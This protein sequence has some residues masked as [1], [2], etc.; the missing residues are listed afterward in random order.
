MSSLSELTEDDADAAKKDEIVKTYDNQKETKRVVVG[1]T[2]PKPLTVRCKTE[3]SARK[4][5][6]KDTGT[7]FQF[8]H[9]SL[10]SKRDLHKLPRLKLG[11]GMSMDLS[12][13]VTDLRK[14]SLSLPSLGASK[15]PNGNNGND[16]EPDEYAATV[17]LETMLKVAD[18]SSMMQDWD[19]YKCWSSRLYFELRHAYEQ[20]RNPHDPARNWF[21]A[22]ILFWDGYVTPLAKR[23]ESTGAFFVAQT[24]DH[25]DGLLLRCVADNRA[26]WL[27][28]GREFTAWLAKKWSV[29]R[30]EERK[31]K[32]KKRNIVEEKACLSTEGDDVKHSDSESR[33][34][35]IMGRLKCVFRP[36]KTQREL[37]R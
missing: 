28:E 18:V 30:E 26:R 31:K 27:K 5:D 11:I 6:S 22:Q 23:L 4:I 17:L 8:L 29:V 3:P 7:S 19:R 16:G 36:L 35:S 1:L 10:L 9:N 2:R 20:G 12:G 25:D 34:S 13:N 37:S 33:T 15:L 14:S 24:V 32:P 21:E